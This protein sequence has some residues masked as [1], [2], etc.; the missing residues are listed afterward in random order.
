MHPIVLRTRRKRSSSASS[1]VASD[2]PTVALC[3]SMYLVVERTLMS[4]PKANTGCSAAVRKV[5]STASSTPALCATEATAATSVSFNVGLAG[6]SI[7]ISLVRGS[8]AAATARTSEVSTKLARTPTPSN[9]WRK[10]RTV[11]PYTTSEMMVWSPCLR[12]DKNSVVIAAMPVPKHTAGGAS[13]SAPRE[14]SNAST[15]GF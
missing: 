12:R 14:R 8:T 13:S 2:P 9:I 10:R 5:L 6:V 3:P 4:A 1:F 15:V 11:P 7:K